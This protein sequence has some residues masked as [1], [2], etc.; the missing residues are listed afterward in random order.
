MRPTK[1]AMSCRPRRLVSV[2]FR[3]WSSARSLRKAP[4][5]RSINRQQ[6]LYHFRR[7]FRRRRS[8]PNGREQARRL[9]PEF[10]L[11]HLEPHDS[12]RDQHHG[13][14]KCRNDCPFA[15]RFVH[16]WGRLNA[17]PGRPV[18]CWRSPYPDHLSVPRYFRALQCCSLHISL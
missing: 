7:P 18:P 14:N 1:G 12:A 15:R 5:A 16:R 11:L 17:S 4:G 2:S 6:R 13:K 10:F 3:L 8:P 9:R